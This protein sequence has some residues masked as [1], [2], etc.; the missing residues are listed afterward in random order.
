MRGVQVRTAESENNQDDGDCRYRQPNRNTSAVFG[1]KEIYHPN[2]DHESDRRD[3]RVCIRNAQIAHC[4]PTA[5]RRSDD[6]IRHQQECAN[7]SE[8]A[9]LL[10]RRGIHSTAIRKMRA[11]NDVVVTD[12]GSENADRENNR[13]RRETRRGKRQ[14]E[15]VRLARS[16]IAI[17]ERSGALPI[18]VARAMH[19]PCLTQSYISHRIRWGISLARLVAGKLFLACRSDWRARLGPRL[20]FYAGAEFDDAIRRKTEVGSYVSGIARHPG[21]D[22]AAPRG[23]TEFARGQNGFAPDKISGAHRIKTQ[24]RFLLRARAPM[25]HQVSR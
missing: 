11:N 10:A 8:E 19:S 2:H 25:A 12:N 14:P 23:K 4:R 21:E 16:P 13:E 3:S 15:N 9:A 20:N 22:R 17:E 7:G 24:S 5:Q 18:D 1:A 6:E